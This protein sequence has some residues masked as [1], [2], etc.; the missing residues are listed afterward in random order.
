MFIASPPHSN[1]G[2]FSIATNKGF[3][4]VLTRISFDLV[5]GCEG[6]F[7][8]SSKSNSIVTTVVIRCKQN[9]MFVIGVLRVPQM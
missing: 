5:H 6:S 7:S 8:S 2:L 1:L 9:V 4:N 3:I